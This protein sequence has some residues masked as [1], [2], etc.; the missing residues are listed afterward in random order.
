MSRRKSYADAAR[1]PRL[2]RGNAPGTITLP[3]SSAPSLNNAH[4]LH[5]LVSGLP[6]P[7]TVL[8]LTGT[9]ELVSTPGVFAGVSGGSGGRSGGSGSGRSGREGRDAGRDGSEGRRE[10]SAAGKLRAVAEAAAGEGA[11]AFPFYSLSQSHGEG[12]DG[13]GEER[14]RRMSSTTSEMLNLVPR[15]G[16]MGADWDRESP[17]GLGIA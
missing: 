10:R 6:S 14:R 17:I 3:T 5:T 9:S 12:A 8:P 1:P 11:G 7:G 4:P 2:L 16:A 13:G 15:E